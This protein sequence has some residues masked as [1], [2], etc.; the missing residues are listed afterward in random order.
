MLD[1]AT[2]AIICFGIVGRRL[3]MAKDVRVLIATWCGRR[4]GGAASKRQN[5]KCDALNA[6]RK[7]EQLER[8]EHVR[9]LDAL[10]ALSDSGTV[11]R[12]LQLA[13]ECRHRDAVWL[14]ALVSG[15]GADVTPEGVV[16]VMT[17]Q[18][19][20]R[21]LHLS[22]K[23][24]SDRSHEACGRD[25]VRAGAWDTVRVHVRSGARDVGIKSSGSAGSLR[26][27]RAGPLLR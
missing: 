27:Q 4:P 19:D 22:W 21:A 23:E 11:A 26:P 17:E 14:I 7:N 25:G 10:V 2:R 13:R 12:G 3:G 15:D 1:R 5:E 6:T 16:A 24:A 8:A 9:W 18:G 20:P